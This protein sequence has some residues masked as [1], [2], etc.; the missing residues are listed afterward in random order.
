MG[1]FSVEPID[2][3]AALLVSSVCNGATI[4]DTDVG[5]EGRHMVMLV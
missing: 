1:I 5:D 2:K 3:T 4:D